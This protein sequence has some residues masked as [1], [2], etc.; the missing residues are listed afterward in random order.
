MYYVRKYALRSNKEYNSSAKSNVRG[1][2]FPLNAK[3]YE[4][5]LYRVRFFFDTTEFWNAKFW[6]ILKIFQNGMM[7]VAFCTVVGFELKKVQNQKAKN[8]HFWII[9]K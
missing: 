9:E 8:E 3:H 6:S 7:P 2:C 5:G 4:T 1:C